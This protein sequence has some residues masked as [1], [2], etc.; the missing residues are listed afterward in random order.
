[1]TL[2]QRGGDHAAPQH[3]GC[4]DQVDSNDIPRR[5]SLFPD[6]KLAGQLLPLAAQLLL[7]DREA[8]RETERVG[9]A[10]SADE[11]EERILGQGVGNGHLH[12]PGQA[13]DLQ[14]IAAGVLLQDRLEEEA[15][16]DGQSLKGAKI[17]LDRAEREELEAVPCL[18][19]KTV[20]K[21]DLEGAVQSRL[22]G[23]LN[24]VES[25]RLAGA[26]GAGESIR[27]ADMEGL[28][29]HPHHGRRGG[30]VDDAGNSERLQ[31]ELENR[32]TRRAARQHFAGH[33]EGAD[34]KVRAGRHL[35]GGR[36]RLPNSIPADVLL[37][38]KR[39]RGTAPA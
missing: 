36:R 23:D 32:K 28:P 39:V 17:T 37:V 35:V 12:P 2:F 8:A 30:Q 31:G 38:G 19:D 11:C 26:G 27:R 6:G 18:G 34:L 29:P 24:L 5:G 3:G 1:M 33:L 10:F 4:L 16:A 25:V 7:Q 20:E 15:A 21:D 22:S 13:R 14:H 9:G